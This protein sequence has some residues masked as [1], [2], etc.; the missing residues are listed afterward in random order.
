MSDRMS[1]VA[2]TQQAET[3]Y[4]A[5]V[6]AA[7]V[8]ARMRA[9]LPKQYLRLCGKPLLEHTLERLCSHPRIRGVVVVIAPGDTHL[10]HITLSC[11]TP[12]V[13]VEGGTQ[14]CHS[15][16]NGLRRLAEMA[17]PD[18][19]VLVHDAA[20]PCVRHRDIDRLIDALAGHPVGGLLGVPVRDTMKRADAQGRV[21]ETVNRGGLW[22]AMTP[23]MF[24]L[25]ALRS[26]LITAIDKD[27]LVT[28]EAAAMEMTGARPQ[29]IEGHSDNI[30]VTLPED[31]PLA[32]FFLERQEASAFGG[33]DDGQ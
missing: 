25:E 10:R 8:G 26:A 12:F 2:G 6:P 31:L 23:Q 7:G 28:D 5:V 9:D 17:Q 11:D 33:L 15:V 3:H 22:H 32:E 14:R 21:Y 4:W 29:L 24:R 30:K 16:L 27:I 20:R 1:P 19:W 13:S 18:D